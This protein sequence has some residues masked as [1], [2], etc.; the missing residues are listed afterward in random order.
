MTRRMHRK[1][2]WALTD[3]TIL[4]AEI[5]VIVAPSIEMAK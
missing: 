4:A 1:T 5:A 3:H 2:V